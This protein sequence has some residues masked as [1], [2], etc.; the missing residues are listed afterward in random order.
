MLNALAHAMAAIK[1]T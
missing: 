1:I